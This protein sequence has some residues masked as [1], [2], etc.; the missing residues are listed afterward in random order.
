MPN[1][2]K[3]FTV[4]LLVYNDTESYS[5]SVIGRYTYQDVSIST[6]QNSG[7]VAAIWRSDYDLCGIKPFTTNSEVTVGYRNHSTFNEEDAFANPYFAHFNTNERIEHASI[8]FW[9][10]NTRK[11]I[12]NALKKHI[13]TVEAKISSLGEVKWVID[14]ISNGAELVYQLCLLLLSHYLSRV[15]LFSTTPA[16]IFSWRR[17][18]LVIKSF[19]CFWLIPYFSLISRPVFP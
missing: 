1:K 18:Y 11:D 15:F 9:G 13:D 17:L 16:A 2:S 7:A 10:V 3:G 6:F 8:Y 12:V 5:L 4:L 19:S 14:G